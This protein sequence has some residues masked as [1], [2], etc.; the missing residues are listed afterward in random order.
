MKY[1]AG[2]VKT[3]KDG[4]GMETYIYKKRKW[5][6][7]K[8]VHNAWVHTPNYNTPEEA[9]DAVSKKAIEYL[10]MQRKKELC[11]LWVAER[12]NLHEI[13]NKLALFEKITNETP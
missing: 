10:T 9:F 5:L 4:A 11:V 7:D 3:F 1:Y 8:Q 13:I 6:W 2:P 12:P